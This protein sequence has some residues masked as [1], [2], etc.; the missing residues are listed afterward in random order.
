MIGITTT[1]P[2][3]V[4]LAAGETPVDLNNIF[5][6]SPDKDAFI[7]QAEADGYPSGTC[8]WIKGIY[9][10]A[11]ADPEIN[12][13]IA[14]IQGD[15]SNTHALMETLQFHGKEVI[16]FDYPYN[17][18]RD[19]LELSIKKLAQKFGTDMDAAEKQQ[20]ILQGI[21]KKLG[22]LDRT[23]WE[24]SLPGADHG[25]ISGE[26][27]HRWLVSSS[28]FNTDYVKY[29]SELDQFLVAAGEK[30]TQ[31][32]DLR[33]GY[34]GVPPIFTNLYE[35]LEQRQAKVVYNEVQRQFS[36][37]F[38]DCSLV[39]QYLQYTYPYDI[40]GRIEDIKREIKL[41]R[42]D[43]LVHYTQMFCFRQI[44]DIIVRKLIDIPILTLEGDRPG[45]IDARVGMRI[46]G[47]LEM[48][49]NMK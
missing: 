43:G 46:E 14:V 38:K 1:I 12:K 29:E 11:I 49:R 26:E 25:H 23:T 2:A 16:P 10:V 22:Q 18:D 9:S 6:T 8:A 3:E 13:I 48:L 45:V 31:T 5:I 47:F 15:C 42:I 21:R 44:Q 4:L 32:P 24:N 33:L 17:H 27:N 35:F 20:K 36:M 41:R 39:E 40:F 28:D 34:I 30:P 19:L 7:S 37:P